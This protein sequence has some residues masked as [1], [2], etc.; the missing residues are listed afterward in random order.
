MPLQIQVKLLRALQEREI[1]PLGSNAV[2]QVDVRV[3]AASSRNLPALIEEGRFRADLYYRLN[4]VPL[5]IP[6]LRE[7]RDD[8]P[9]LC[10]VLIEDICKAQ[11]LP[12]KEISGA[13]VRLLQSHDWPGNVRELRNVLERACVLS[14]SHVLADKDFDAFHTAS[15]FAK[16]SAPAPNSLSGAV[17]EVERKMICDAL[18]RAGGNKLQM[19]KM[20]GIS[21]SNLYLKL[22]QYRIGAPRDHEG[23]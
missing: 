17:E 15:G 19:A 20:L 8:I 18:A 11:R 3:I 22:Q 13:A 5:A 14:G 7:R 4:V 16:S 1:E 23:A 6:P 21:R 12:V 2:T 10:E 9:L